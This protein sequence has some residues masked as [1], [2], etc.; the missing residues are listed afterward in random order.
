MKAMHY[1]AL[2]MAAQVK[3]PV[4]SFCASA[5]Q[6]RKLGL[7]HYVLSREKNR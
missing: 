7:T 4:A 1:V 6:D 3:D 2:P 5:W